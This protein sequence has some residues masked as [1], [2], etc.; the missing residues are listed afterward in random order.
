[1]AAS[2]IELTTP[3]STQWARMKGG[4]VLILSAIGAPGWIKLDEIYII[5]CCAQ[6]HVNSSIWYENN[7]LFVYSATQ[8]Y[9]DV[10]VTIAENAKHS[11][12]VILCSF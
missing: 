7:S 8:M 11:F 4:H 3:D 6:K 1:M 2:G 12:Y 5:F 9:S 10:I